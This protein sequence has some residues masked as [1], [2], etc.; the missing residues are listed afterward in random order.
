MSATGDAF[1]NDNRILTLATGCWPLASL[2][3]PKLRR[4]SRQSGAACR[5][6]MRLDV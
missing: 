1:H 6:T 2:A 4:S 3:T 5:I